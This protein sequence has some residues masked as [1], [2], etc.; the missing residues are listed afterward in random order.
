MPFSTSRRRFRLRFIADFAF[1]HAILLLSLMLVAGFA[2]MPSLDYVFFFRV[3]MLFIFIDY[4]FFAY[5]ELLSLSP[6]FRYAITP[7]FH[8]F[9]PRRFAAVFIDF[10][11]FDYF[12]RCFSRFSRNMRDAERALIRE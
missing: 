12:S 7:S 5:A 8:D 2:A 3:S 10:H 9:M 11:Y 6:F 4:A 1:C